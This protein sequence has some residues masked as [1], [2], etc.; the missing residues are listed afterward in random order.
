LVNFLFFCTFLATLD[1]QAAPRQSDMTLFDLKPFQI[2]SLLR[3]R[4]S[5][6]FS[7]IGQG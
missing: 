6:E 4:K 7:V 3:F 2:A 1:F 5:Q